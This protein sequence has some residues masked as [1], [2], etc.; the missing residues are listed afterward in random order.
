MLCNMDMLGAVFLTLM[1]FNAIPG[2]AMVLG[3]VKIINYLGCRM[4]L[5]QK[6]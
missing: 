5:L 4:A 3:K 1:T 2:A 6:T